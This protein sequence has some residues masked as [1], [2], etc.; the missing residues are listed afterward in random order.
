MQNMHVV[1]QY[2]LNEYAQAFLKYFLPKIEDMCNH[3]K[4]ES[5]VFNKQQ[6]ISLIL[7][8]V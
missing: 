7:N 1:C 8:S 4:Q 2:I 6:S 3:T 5:R